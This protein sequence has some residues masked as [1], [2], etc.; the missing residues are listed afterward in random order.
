MSR[1]LLVLVVFLVSCGDR[2]SNY[3]SNLSPLAENPYIQLPLGAVKAEGWLLGQLELAAQGMTGRLDEIWE[4]VGPENGWLGGK[5]ETWERG[6]YWLD[7]LVPLAYLLDDK[8]LIDKAQKWI[9]WSLNSQRED[10]YFGPASD[11]TRVFGS[12][13]RTLAWQEK[14]KEDWWP[15][16][17]MLKVLQSYYE[18]TGDERVIPFMQKYF[19]YQQAHIEQW[20]LDHW[21]HWA[22]TRGGENL[23]SIYWL[24]NHTGD[25]NLLKLGQTIFE[26]TENWTERFEAD[27]PQDWHG[28]NTGMGI[29]QPAVYYQYSKDKRY[30]EAVEAGITALMKY[31]GQINGLW[32]GDELLHGTDPTHGTEFCTVVEYMFS[33]ETVLQIS[34]N[35]VYA[36]RLERVAFNALPTQIKADF[37]GR[38]Y[39]QLPN[40]VICNRE[41]HNFSTKHTEDEITY[42]LETGYGCCTANM[43]QGWPKFVANLWY[44][45]QDNGLAALV[46]G[47]S[48]VTALVGNGAEVTFLEETGYP[49][50]ETIK[51]TYTTD[52]T[53]VFPLHLRIPGWCKDAE[54]LVNGKHNSRPEAGV[55]AKIS[56]TW[57]EG[58]VVELRLPMK[59]RISHWHER[60]AGVELGSLVFALKIQEK[61]ER[62]SGE[63]PYG[64]YEVYPEDA[65]N[66]FLLRKYIDKPEEHFVVKHAEAVPS[67]PWTTDAAPVW[68]LAKGKRMPEWQLYGGVT[69]PTPFSPY[70]RPKEYEGPEE[71][72]VL[73]PY[74]ATTLR[75]SEF[76]VMR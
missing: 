67:Q 30:L 48:R 41:W 12:D 74:G 23:A 7:G 15:H 4:D 24:Y 19:Q 72:L 29:K 1:K 63:D 59:V 33:L 75:I 45:T 66:Y 31:H 62:I 50:T 56:R 64:D 65:W 21:T 44:A 53:N 18:A 47:P 20:P 76:P 54:I 39:Y 27:Y 2:N 52:R 43:H 35:P 71:D 34:G 58:D 36:D 26:Q 49:F 40:Q 16:M 13:E 73:I 17:I 10:G 14:H 9:E 46:Y 8:V 6:P 32:S 55:V 38:Q 57:S 70:W 42:G 61:W 3:I 22:K 5:G 51:F 11:S 25:K 28:V 37:T 68:I 60:A 69:G